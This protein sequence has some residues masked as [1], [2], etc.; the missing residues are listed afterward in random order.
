MN[1]SHEYSDS[2]IKQKIKLND[3]L[4]CQAPWCK[5]YHKKGSLKRTLSSLKFHKSGELLKYYMY[6]E[7]CTTEYALDTNGLLCERSFF[8]QFAW[9]KVRPLLSN[10]STLKEI[11]LKLDST[12]DKVTRSIIFLAANHL[13]DQEDLPVNIPS[14][15]NEV[16]MSRIKDNFIKGI[17]AKKIRSELGLR[18]NDFLYYWLS[19]ECQLLQFSKKVLRPDKVS[20]KE[21]RERMFTSIVEELINSRTPLTISSIC[22]KL[23]I[24][25]ETL[26]LWGL[27]PKVREYKKVQ[28]DLFKESYRN[29]ILNKVNEV[30]NKTH[31]SNN[32]ISSEE[33]YRSIGVNRSVLVRNF[34]DL[35]KYIHERLLEYN[36]QPLYICL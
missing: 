8:I 12:Q 3:S 10:C 32:H 29:E 24:C 36:L 18:Y 20:S 22:K 31:S 15:R 19:I 33:F 5:N 28:T 17:P 34:P 9:N 7:S 11:T 4:T 30:L 16:I 35:T 13:I 14:I 23:E 21:E 6:C 25:P 27:L 2:N 1:I 26:R